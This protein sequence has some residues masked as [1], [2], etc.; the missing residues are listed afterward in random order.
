MKKI[1][2]LIFILS[3]LSCNSNKKTTESEPKLPKLNNDLIGI[4]EYKTPEQT[5]NHYIWIDT[6]NSQYNGFYYGTEDGSGHGVF[7]YGNKM[8]NLNLENNKISFEIKERELYK[9][10]RFRIIKNRRNLK[11]DSISGFSN[12]QLKYSG[13][14]SKNE[15]KINCESEYEDCWESNMDFKK[16]IK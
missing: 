6:L 5:E 2:I 9:T 13:I 15:F 10:T 3:F 14:I 8:E 16:L 1:S 11:K 12:S 7:F 4:Y